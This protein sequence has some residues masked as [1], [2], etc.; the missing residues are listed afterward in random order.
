MLFRSEVERRLRWP[1]PRDALEV[2]QRIRNVAELLTAAAANPQESEIILK[3]RYIKVKNLCHGVMNVRDGK[4]NELESKLENDDFH[5]FQSELR[6]RCLQILEKKSMS[7]RE[8]RTAVNH[9]AAATKMLRRVGYALELPGREFKY[10]SSS[11]RLL[12]DRVMAHL[13][14]RRSEAR[15]DSVNKIYLLSRIWSEA[16]SDLTAGIVRAAERLQNIVNRAKEDAREL[17]Q[18]KQD[19]RAGCHWDDVKEA[20]SALG[21]AVAAK[22]MAQKHQIGRAHV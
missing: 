4:N 7:L 8:W 22:R 15:R 6:N 18:I 16:V 20:N 13:S 12:Y 14:A 3:A 19:L 2:R 10:I 21:H 1:P 11:N 17:S 9:L 5:A